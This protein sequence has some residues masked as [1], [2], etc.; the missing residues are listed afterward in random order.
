MGMKDKFQDQAQ[1]MQHK[2]KQKADEAKQ[3]AQQSQQQRG[4]E[5]QRG[6]T[7]RSVR[8]QEDRFNQDY[9]A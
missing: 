3:R 9:D 6:D 7:D 8:E 2:G 1:Q 5:P 4:R